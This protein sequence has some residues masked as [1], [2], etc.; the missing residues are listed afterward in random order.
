LT[1]AWIMTNVLVARPLLCDLET[2]YVNILAAAMAV[3]V[4]CL[5]AAV[6][7]HPR[8]QVLS[9]LGSGMMAAMGGAALVIWVFSSQCTSF[10]M[11]VRQLIAL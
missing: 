11:F 8:A 6:F 3:G 10:R 2:N 9:F 5:V 1:Y 7:D 4:G